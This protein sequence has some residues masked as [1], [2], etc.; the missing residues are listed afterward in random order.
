MPS[1]NDEP[2]ASALPPAAG[3]EAAFLAAYG[4]ALGVDDTNQGVLANASR[5]RAFN[6]RRRRQLMTAALAALAGVSFAT[7]TFDRWRERTLSVLEFEAAR[8]AAQARPALDAQ[9]RLSLL[10]RERV[11]LHEVSARRIDP[12]AALAAI[13]HALPKDVVVLSARSNGE[14][15]RV[16]GTAANAAALVP[17]LDKAGAF[18]NVRSLSASSRFQ[19]GVRM[20]ETFSIA[21]RVRPKP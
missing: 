16:D 9:S 4:A 18:E 15:W 2:I 21:F 5:R 6:A 11:T 7:L 10:S 13:G 19:D 17:A 14:E 20:R 3:I 8:L 12:S 1:S